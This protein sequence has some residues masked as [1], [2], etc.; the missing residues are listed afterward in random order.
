MLCFL[1]ESQRW[2]LFPGPFP[3]DEIPGQNSSSYQLSSDFCPTGNVTCFFC[4]AD[5]KDGMSCNV[6]KPRPVNDCKY[7]VFRNL[8]EQRQK[9]KHFTIGFDRILIGF[10]WVTYKNR[11]CLSPSSTIIEVSSDS[12]VI[13]VDNAAHCWKNLGIGTNG[14]PL[15]SPG[16]PKELYIVLSLYLLIL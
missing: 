5:W 4:A 2:C 9:P 8:I 13:V 14:D 7:G 6:R 11:I 10:V 15:A 16:G 3:A 1:A 12:S